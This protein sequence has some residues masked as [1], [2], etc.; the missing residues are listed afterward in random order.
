MKSNKII[1]QKII[2]LA[3]LIALIAL[4][5]LG[6]NQGSARRIL[7]TGFTSIEHIAF[8]LLAVWL[9]AVISGSIGRSVL[10][11]FDFSKLSIQERLVIESMIGL[12]LISIGTLLLGM[13]GYFNKYLWL[14][15]AIL[16]V[17]LFRSVWEW[18]KAWST[19]LSQAEAPANAWERFIAN[20][21]QI[22]LIVALVLALAPPFAWDGMAYHLEI[23]QRYIETGIIGQH[24][25]IHFFGSPQSMEMLYGLVMILTGSD[26][27]PAVL[28]FYMGLLGLIAIARLLRRYTSIKAASLATLLIL[29]SFN[30]WQLFAWPYI[31]LALMSYGIVAV[32][33]FT[34]WRESNYQ[35]PRWL[36]LAGLFVGMAAGV[37]YTAAP[38]I[39]ALAILIFLRQPK[40][41]IRNGLFFGIAG[42]LAFLPWM[43]KGFLLYDNPIYPYLFNGV[44]W[45]NIRSFNFRETGKGLLDGSL[46]FQM[47]IPLLP[48]AATIFG[49]DKVTPY[50]FTTGPFLLTLPFLL[51]LG[52]NHLSNSAK[53]LARDIIPLALIS[54][55]FWM[56]IAA[57]S[58]IGG[59][60]RLMI[61]A[62]PLAAILG[63][64]AYHSIENWPRRPLDILFILQAA[65]IL[66]VLLGLFDFLHYFSKTRVIEYH[67]ASISREQYLTENVGILYRAMQAL[68]ELPA[69]STVLFLWEPKVYY[70][71]DDL[72]CVA[73]LLL[74]NWAR[75][76]QQGT[77]PEDMMQ[78]WRDSGIDYFL[79]F[80]YSDSKF[81]DGYSLWL[82]YHEF[83][84]EQNDSFSQFFFEQ[85]EAIWSDDIA[86]TI[87]GWKK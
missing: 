32:I 43:L 85:V 58:G 79:I 87:Y 62:L 45:D 74:D 21:S 54:L 70:C 33:A 8:D 78:Q 30:L 11:S 2:L 40:Q 37:K 9:L 67:T 10:K 81:P 7:I 38:L 82:S 86:Y 28:H 26:H 73:D 18:L 22:A 23:P 83:A 50:R 57:T 12:G 31:D 46:F 42:L 17:V 59:Q 63:A 76:I 65:I 1:L 15:L 53:T 6:H 44:G 55:L 27:A 69:G 14:I 34:Q 29:A 68:D 25:D 66:S 47:Q 36:I 19:A 52:W 64:I 56:F 72:I 4:Y 35:T 41:V 16:A 51:F 60:T 5:F 77:A 3:A 49:I 13:L 20:F 71:P 24:L 80:D 39:I 61:I 48:F 84:R 75:P